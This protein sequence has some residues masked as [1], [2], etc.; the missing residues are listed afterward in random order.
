MIAILWKTFI[1]CFVNSIT[2]SATGL[3]MIH[4][5]RHV[6]EEYVRGRLTTA[7]DN[8]IPSVESK[9]NLHDRINLPSTGG[10]NSLQRHAYV[11][12]SSQIR[13]EFHISIS[14]K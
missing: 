2:K 12:A 3:F 5:W 7:P 11:L 6:T 13:K 4:A 14:G 9:Y 10:A 1:R 8:H